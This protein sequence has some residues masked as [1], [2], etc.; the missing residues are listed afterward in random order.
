MRLISGAWAASHT[1][2][3]A[4]RV[5]KWK[6]TPGWHRPARPRRCL[7]LARLTVTSSSDSMRRCGSKRFSF[8]RPVSMTYPQSSTVT[9]VSAMFVEST[10]LRTPGGGRSKTLRCSSGGRSECRGRTQLRWGSCPN[11]RVPSSS[12]CRVWISLNPG[13]KTSTASASELTSRLPLPPPPPCLAFLGLPLAPLLAG[14]AMSHSRVPPYSATNSARVY[15]TPSCKSTRRST[16]V[17]AARASA[18]SPPRGVV[19]TRFA[20]L[21][22]GALVLGGGGGGNLSIAALRRAWSQAAITSGPAIPRN[23]CSSATSSS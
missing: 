23:H 6:A 15:A 19:A 20:P 14:L 2:S 17:T 9:A 12:S 16:S 7:A 1:A 5:I 10:T 18:A 3:W 22:F 13:R 21:T 11:S 4:W 8:M